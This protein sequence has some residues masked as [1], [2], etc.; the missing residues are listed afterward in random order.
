MTLAAPNSQGEVV[1]AMKIAGGGG[2]QAS[3]DTTLT[4]GMDAQ[5]DGCTITIHWLN[6]PAQ[7]L[8]DVQ[9]GQ[10]LA[11]VQRFDEALAW[12]VPE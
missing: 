1:A 4:F 12:T 2:F 3:N 9:P 8:T 5:T 6:S 7:T 11:I 10:S